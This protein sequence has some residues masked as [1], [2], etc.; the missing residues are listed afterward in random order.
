MAGDSEALLTLSDK[1]ENCCHAM[2]EL[3]SGELDCTNNLKQIYDRLPDHLQAKWR[4][5]A[6][7]F[8]DKTAGREPTLKDFSSFISRE[9]LTEN[10]SVY[11]R[12]NSTPVTVKADI[13]KKCAF[14]PKFTD[15]MRVT[16]VATDVSKPKPTELKYSS[17]KDTCKVCKGSHEIHKCPVF[18]AKN[19]NWRRRFSKLN[20]NLV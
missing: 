4:K 18:L 5:S 12:S 14:H 13:S 2:K 9:S 7:M 20:G 10:D 15:S 1:I 17:I 16:T 8:R 19:A 3:K 11:R 6:R